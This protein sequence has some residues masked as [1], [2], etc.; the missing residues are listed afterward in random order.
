MTS[1]WIRK[2]QSTRQLY[3]LT[4]VWVKNMGIVPSL[5]AKVRAV[6][7]ALPTADCTR[8]MASHRGTPDCSSVPLDWSRDTNEQRRTAKDHLYSELKDD[9]RSRGRQRKRYKDA[10][11]ANLKRC[12]IVPADLETLLME[13][14]KWWSLCKTS[15]RQ[16]ESDRIRDLEA[17]RE[18][19]KTATIRSAACYPC[20]VCGQ[21][22]ASRIGL[23]THF[24]THQHWLW[25]GI[26]VLTA[27][28]N[29][30]DNIV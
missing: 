17:K 11:K 19:R 3:Y 2:W 16:F 22:C 23:S 26:R 5:C 29:N 4:A 13:W 7:H 18:Q 10:L 8:S 25:S 14:S 12:S 27:Q 1:D 28:S 20:Q 30:N 24:R 9:A 21:T 15:I 6:S